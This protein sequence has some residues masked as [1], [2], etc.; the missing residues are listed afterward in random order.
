MNELM[1]DT[2]NLEELKFGLA[3]WPVSGVTSNPS[4]LKKE[5]NIDVYKRL[6]EIRR[7]CTNGRSLH[8]QVVSTTTEEII[9][10]AK[11]IISM[12]GHD[13]FIKIP[14][15]TAGLPAIKALA[16]EGVNVTATA[17]YSS[18]QGILAVLAGAKYVAIYYNRMENNCT[19]ADKV[20][21][22]IRS[23]IDES[24]SDSKILAASFKNIAE[25]V[26]AFANGAHSATVGY[27]IVKNA[28]GMASID[29]A[30]QSFTKD[31]EEIHGKGSNMATILD[32]NAKP[33]VQK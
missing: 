31:F 30:V 25:V 19:D 7:L 4:I 8:V 11:T 16:K 15:S 14:V 23:F 21:K 20:I 27:D 22:Q 12:I 24:G 13:T 17:I 2:A 29:F 3:H 18:M 6:Q 10:E 9:K 33:V 1:L 5:G 26:N 32:D 28:L